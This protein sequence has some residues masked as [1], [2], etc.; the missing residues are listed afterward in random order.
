MSLDLRLVVGRRWLKLLEREAAAPDG[1]SA[2][3]RDAY[4]DAYG[5]PVP[6]PTLPEDAAVCAHPETWQQAG[7]AA[8]RAMDGIALLEYLED[9]GHAAHDG[10]GAAPADEARLATLAQKLRSWFRSLIVQ[11]DA[12][13]SEAWLPSRLEYQFGCS[14]TDGSGEQVMRAEEYFHGTLDWHAL[15]RMPPGS[16][17]GDAPIP[18]A[19]PDRRV[20]TFVPTEVTYE[21]MP[22]TRW[23]AFEDGRTNFGDVRPDTTDLGKLLLMEFA[24]VYANDWFVLP[25]TMDIGRVAEVQ[26]IAVTSRS[27]TCSASG[28]GSS[29]FAL[30]V[31][32]GGNG[33]CSPPASRTPSRGHPS[34]A[35]CCSRPQ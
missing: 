14:A 31:P 29:R 4:R 32:T 5:V 35:L 22:R 24:L 25:Y 3:Y 30:P 9:S 28:S 1:L 18:P 26:G 34:R 23:W 12:P 11:P 10:I 27:P 19:D 6:D 21:G 20:H 2:D 33:G 13:E 8:E 17:L 16:R 7:A 15:D